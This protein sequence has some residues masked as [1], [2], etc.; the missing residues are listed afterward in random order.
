MQINFD[1]DGTI[2]DFYGVENWLDYLK[3]EDVF[4]YLAA[5]ALCNL[6]L[7]AR[8]IHQLQNAGAEINIISWTSKYGSAEF[9]EEIKIAKMKWLAKH[10]PSV[11]FNSIS[12]IPY[13]TPKSLYGSGILFDDEEKNRKDWNG[14]AYDVT[15]MLQIL[16]EMVTEM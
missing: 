2:A 15:D 14:T 7:L 12:I 9:M 13:G 3:A 4:P 6:S 5:K 16:K 11:E 10:L 1:M 8:L